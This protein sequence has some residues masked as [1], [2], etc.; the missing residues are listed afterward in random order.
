MW[1]TA[2]VVLILVFI[3][4]SFYRKGKVLLIYK[5]SSDLNFLAKTQTFWMKMK[6][7]YVLVSFKLCMN[8]LH[9]LIIMSRKRLSS[10]Y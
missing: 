9:N 2:G 5:L 10:T 8:G 4:I 7:F 6:K 1:E 3:R